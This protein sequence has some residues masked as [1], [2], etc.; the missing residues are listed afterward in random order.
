[1]S[2]N[3]LLQK[4]TSNESVRSTFALKLAL[5][6]LVLAASISALRTSYDKGYLTCANSDAYLSGIGIL[7]RHGDYRLDVNELH[8]Q[9]TICLLIGAIGLWLRRPS[10]LLLSLLALT[11]IGTLYL[12]WYLDTS[13]FMRE[14]EISD[15]SLLQGAGKQHWI[16]LREGTWWDFV[17]LVL[18][19][20]LSVWLVKRLIQVSSSASSAPR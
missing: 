17:V 6:V 8:L 9:I 18:V 20:A 19:M 10:S 7:S 11:W 3:R 4:L 15:F 13:L 1:M 12:R 14:Q 5:P 16:P 2:T